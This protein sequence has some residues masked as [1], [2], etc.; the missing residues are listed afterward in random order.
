MIAF[1]V[2]SVKFHGEHLNH[3][4]EMFERWCNEIKPELFACMDEV[5]GTSKHMKKSP[6][7]PSLTPIS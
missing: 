4:K 5:T 7:Q 6:Q 1:D 3:G 2:N